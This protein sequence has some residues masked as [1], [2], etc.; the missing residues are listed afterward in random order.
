MFEVFSNTFLNVFQAFKEVTVPTR[1]M[2]APPADMIEQQDSQAM[3]VQT[4]PGVKET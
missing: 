4:R 3:E 2:G 1:V